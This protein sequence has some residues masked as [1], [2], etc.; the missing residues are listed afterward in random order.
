MEELP[1][2]FRPRIPRRRTQSLPGEVTR[3]ASS[4]VCVGFQ[5]DGLRK[6]FDPRASFEPRGNPSCRL[7]LVHHKPRGILRVLV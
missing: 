2:G 4:G 7:G 5:V 1:G 3:I 6:A